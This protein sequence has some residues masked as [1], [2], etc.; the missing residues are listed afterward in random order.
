MHS[1]A[2]ARR[3]RAVYREYMPQVAARWAPD[4]PGN[5]VILAELER[6]TER[7]LSSRGLVP[8]GGRSVLDIGCGYGHFLRFL[9]T[10]GADPGNIHG[11][12]L[13]EERLVH[14]RAVNPGVDI[15]V[16]NAEALPF[17]D[18]SFDVVLL[19]SVLTSILDL[20]VRARVADETA[21]VLA[22]HGLIVFYDFR[23]DHPTN[24]NV[25]GVGR[26]EISRL[27]PGFDVS[28]QT[29]TVLPPLARRLGRLTPTLYPALARVP[30]LRSHLFGALE[31]RDAR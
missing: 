9:R 21:R 24:P 7:L 12:D 3:L 28:L 5:Q 14:A 29:T 31:R 4:N 17:P 16:A 23:F 30:A 8:L 26:R 19:F 10:L 6:G 25:R 18:R 20:D 27:F 13:I 22:P 15:R 11:V 2:E 1:E